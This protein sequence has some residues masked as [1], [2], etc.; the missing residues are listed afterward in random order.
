MKNFD[1]QIL[2]IKLK[3]NKQNICRKKVYIYNVIYFKISNLLKV[4]TI[5]LINKLDKKLNKIRK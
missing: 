2:I 3:R 1:L 4:E 5:E